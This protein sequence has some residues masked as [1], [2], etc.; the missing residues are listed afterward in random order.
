MPWTGSLHRSPW[1]VVSWKAWL[2][3]SEKS[4]AS[5]FELGVWSFDSEV[6][7]SFR[8]GKC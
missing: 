5:R 1:A 7:V 3:L 8:L 2:I 6:V 4:R